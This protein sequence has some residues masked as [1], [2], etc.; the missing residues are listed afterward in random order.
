[1]F[2]KIKSS[3]FIDALQFDLVHH[4]EFSLKGVLKDEKGSVCST[5][6]REIRVNENRVYWRGLQDLP[7]GKYILELTQGGEKM[8]V[9]LVKRI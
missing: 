4:T 5:L 9:N 1:M 3:N 2:A 7:Y 8:K 6:E